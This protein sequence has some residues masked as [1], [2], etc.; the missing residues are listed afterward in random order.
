MSEIVLTSVVNGDPDYGK[1]LCA[2][3]ATVTRQELIDVFYSNLCSSNS[4]SISIYANGVNSKY[5]K[6]FKTDMK[7]FVKDDSDFYQ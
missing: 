4:T 5:K 6:S 7:N 1:K 3:I 2:E